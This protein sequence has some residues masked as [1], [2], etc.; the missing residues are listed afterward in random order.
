MTKVPSAGN[1]NQFSGNFEDFLRRVFDLEGFLTI[2]TQNINTSHTANNSPA[3]FFRKYLNKNLMIYCADH[4]PFW[5]QSH[6]FQQIPRHVDAD[7]RCDL[8][9]FQRNIGV[10]Q[11]WRKWRKIIVFT[12]WESKGPIMPTPQ[13][14]RPY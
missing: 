5:Q 3:L 10:L 11:M 6:A 13:E 12:S 9:T 7:P 14:I 4:F 8:S 2:R 1:F